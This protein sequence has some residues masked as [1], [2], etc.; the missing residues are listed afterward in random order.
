[1]TFYTYRNIKAWQKGLPDMSNTNGVPLNTLGNG[2]RINDPNINVV[3]T[4]G[5]TAFTGKSVKI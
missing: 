1:M 2:T 5:F 3:A 4:G